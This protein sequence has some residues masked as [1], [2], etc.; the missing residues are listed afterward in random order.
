M[1]WFLYSIWFDINKNPAVWVGQEGG[2]GL[3][4]IEI[5]VAATPSLS[6]DLF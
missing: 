3:R 1:G 6:N 4:S 2:S 5:T